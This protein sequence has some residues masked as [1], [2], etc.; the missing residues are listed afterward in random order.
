[1][2]F[3]KDDLYFYKLDIGHDNYRVGAIRRVNEKTVTMDDGHKFLKEEIGKSVRK[4]TNEEKVL[5]EG[6]L[7]KNMLCSRHDIVR[8]LYQIKELDKAIQYSSLA[9][10]DTV[11][12]QAKVDELVEELSKTFENCVMINNELFKLTPS[13]RLEKI[14]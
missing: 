9:T 2:D 1:M 6:T 3:N 13:C 5:Y 4:L 10:V 11:K 12:L 7:F 8:F 14:I